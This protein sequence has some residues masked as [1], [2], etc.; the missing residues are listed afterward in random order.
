MAEFSD[1]VT[2][3]RAVVDPSTSPADLAQIAQLQPSLRPQVAA[4]PNVYPGLLSWLDANGDSA[5]KQAIQARLAT[6]VRSWIPQAVLPTADQRL[7]GT[8][9]NPLTGSFS[10][11]EA[12]M[13]SVGSV[14]QPSNLASTQ[15]APPSPRR[16][17][18]RPWA[19]VIPVVVV[20]LAVALVLVF[21]GRPA[22]Q[23]ESGGKS[24]GPWGSFG[25]SSDDWFISVAQAPDR[26]IIAAGRTGS[27][28]GDF[29][30]TRG[31]QSD[32]VLV[33]FSPSGG[34]VWTKTYG[35]SGEDEFDGVAIATD[36]SIFAVG[37]TDSN[38]GDFPDHNGATAGVVAKFGP[39]GTLVWE[40][41]YQ[42]AGQTFLDS[43]TIADDGSVRAAGT[44]DY[45][46]TGDFPTAAGGTNWTAVVVS[47]GADGQKNWAASYGETT[48]ADFWS[49]IAMPGGAVD[50]VGSAG[51]LG[52]TGKAVI[53][54]I[55]ADGSVD[56][57]HAVGGSGTDVFRSV[58]VMPDGSL[59]VSGYTTSTDG[60]FPATR[61]GEDAVFANFSSDG[62]MAWAK[63]FGGS[64]DDEFDGLAVA[65]SGG[66]VAVGQTESTDGD[67]SGKNSS[68]KSEALAVS[69]SNAGNIN[70]AQTYGGSGYSQFWGSVVA[71]DGS[72]YA[73]GYTDSTDGSFPSKHG[74]DD[75]AVIV[76][77]TPQGALV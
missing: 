58:V 38:D 12:Q 14:V 33:K 71:L 32:A 70:W 5:V 64:S 13:A 49:V 27:T 16:R 9:T 15:P 56:W 35:G 47:L 31:G 24:S 39:D 4:H 25:G 18:V 22:G 8:P 41:T 29:P 77:L 51:D 46:G 57:S 21:T 50:V 43:V 69:L 1:L 6:N 52:E 10:P 53:A 44:T 48:A 63:T 3:T 62:A 23:A 55:G 40:S 67:F 76:K 30:A 42:T 2:A 28:D 68:G 19:V 60:D 72:I 54:E 36:G 45:G 61:G 37:F 75:D 59:M 17:V 66:I 26:S 65:P 11:A 73:A 20:V 34:I 7:V 74:N